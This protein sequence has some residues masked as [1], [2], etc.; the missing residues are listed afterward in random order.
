M[1]ERTAGC[2]EPG[3]LRQLLP[4]SKKSLKSRRSLH[5]AFWAHGA[6][7]IEVSPL[8][9]ALLRGPYRDSTDAQYDTQ[10]N[11]LG[12]GGGVLLDFLYPAG[13]IKFLRKYSGWSSDR[14]D[15]RRG[16]VG[17]GRFGHRLY[18]SSATDS[19]IQAEVTGGGCSYWPQE[20]PQAD[21]NTKSLKQFLSKGNAQDYNEAWRRYKLLDE[22]GRQ[23]LRRV[24][25]EYLM[26]S[27][28]IVDAERILELFEKLPEGERGPEIVKAAIRSYLRLRNLSDAFTLHAAALQRFKV[29]TGSDELLGYL[30]ENSLW[31]RALEMWKD[32]QELRKQHP[33]SDNLF[34]V[35]KGLP[36][37]STRA[38]ELANYINGDLQ[39][40]GSPNVST[41]EFV[42]FAAII[43]RYAMF[44]GTFDQ[45]KFQEFL[46]VL[47]G[48]K[49]DNP[50]FYEVAIGYLLE[51]KQ[52]KMAVDL[53]RSSRRTLDV[54]FSR[55]ILHEV[56][57]VFCAHH[58]VVGMQQVLDDFFRFYTTPTP[59]AYRRCMKEF[60]SLGDADTVHA[61][62]EQYLNRVKSTRIMV[63]SDMAP[64]L[65]VHAKRGELEEVVKHFNAL[66]EKY[67]LQPDL[68]CWNI[69][70][71]AYCEVN[72][73]DGAYA[74][75]E[76]VLNSKHLTPDHYTFGTIM[77]LCVWNGDL[78]RTVEIYELAGKMKVKK[79]NAMVDC[80]VLAHLQD[81]RL[82]EAERICEEAL[83]M[84]LKG[85]RT[86]MWDYLL[87]AHARRRNLANV[88]RI[89]QR[90]V[91]A[92]VD[93]D[94]MTY[95][96]LMQA[97]AMVRQPDRAYTILKEVMK[98]AG[99]KATSFH[100][101]VVMGG[102]IATGEFHK[103]FEVHNRMRQRNM[104]LSA[105]NNLLI[106]K[107]AFREDEQLLHNRTREEQ[108]S[109]S[110]QIFQEVI[111]SM[112][113]EDVASGPLKG[114]ARTPTDIAYP[115][116]MY[117]YVL[118][119]LA[120]HN[121]HA[122]VQELY[123]QYVNSLPKTKRDNQPLS[124]LS[125]LILSKYRE[126]DYASVQ[127]CW[128]LAVSLAS[129][130]GSSVQQLPSAAHQIARASQ[131]DTPVRRVVRLHQLDLQ[132][133]LTTY[134]NTL[135]KQEK[136]DDLVRVV[137]ELLEQGF[138]LS[139]KNWN[140]YI[141][142]LAQA[143][144]IKLAFTLCES[145]LMPGWTGWARIR[146]Q[147]PER[148]RLPLEV[149]ALKKDP[150]YLR[151]IYHTLLYLARSFLELQDMSAESKSHQMLLAE[152]E[153]DCPKTLHAIKT[154]QRIDGDLERKILRGY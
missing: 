109:R 59:G 126:G 25:I 73:V 113:R 12:G 41:S 79:S 131:S 64:I 77:G 145:N 2:L 108:R 123:D 137:N 52:S 129:S 49:M 55:R 62:F 44:H 114:A 101:A 96:A 60:A 61:L 146:W 47:R 7:D 143:F 18:T 10:Q 150:T 68:L 149:R 37:L 152:L 8:W 82:E 78:E 141:G 6:A 90:M 4:A 140:H 51:A 135:F 38:L 32:I 132:R 27:R 99:I 16:R 50:H 144:R 106:M 31:S 89:L 97:L 29:L 9:A 75:W 104:R 72:D 88:N 56:L 127:D 33:T 26:P 69:L 24:V 148:N 122:T 105:S 48:W 35:V 83:N 57:K 128:D 139:N 153:R 11:D 42:S 118:F 93:Y 120:Q 58:S 119:V 14:P 134:M 86:R 40:S 19:S 102:F 21:I 111:S 43:V 67:R 36:K 39:T 91:E 53:Y 15:G 45:S 94:A 30:V 34:G 110:M 71:H 138:L 98:D 147:L 142:I 85:S 76:T 3:S 81:D 151:P 66:E 80:L 70:I 112:D 1:L 124:I 133:I 136:I 103:V 17:L 23:Q 46:D 63:A 54:K 28:A 84:D 20:A 116:M 107:A 115:T 117:G 5:S 13:T 95:A 22:T 121:E 130:R 92:N 100:Y 74:C 125:A 154:M 65:S 87:V